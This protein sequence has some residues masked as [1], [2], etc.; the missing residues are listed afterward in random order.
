MARPHLFSRN[1]VLT[2]QNISIALFE[3][4]EY[5]MKIH[6]YTILFLTLVWVLL[7][8]GLLMGEDQIA[9]PFEDVHPLFYKDSPNGFRYYD[10]LPAH[11][12]YTK[13]KLIVRSKKMD[14]NLREFVYLKLVIRNDSDSEVHIDSMPLMQD[15]AHL[16][17]LFHSNYDEVAKTPKLEEIIQTRKPWVGRYAL[18]AAEGGGPA[19]YIKLKPGQEYELFWFCLN[20]YFDLTKPDTYEFTCFTETVNSGQFYE[21][22]LQSNT[23]TFRILEEP[24]Q[25][26]TNVRETLIF[27]YT[28]PPSGEEVFKQPKPPKN[29]FY[30]SPCEAGII[31]VSPYEYYRKSREELAVKVRQAMDEVQPPAE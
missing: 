27:K 13:L 18:V 10:G 28:N 20:Q 6:C 9:I 30:I 3:R 24:S 12:D 7:G 2:L 19:K 22:P 21:P 8:T 11:G 15:S 4:K 29:V 31:D 23:L 1:G 16:W 26:E 25:E 14:H 5:Q 17:K